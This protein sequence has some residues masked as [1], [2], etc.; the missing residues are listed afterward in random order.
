MSLIDR[1][2]K[3]VSNTLHQVAKDPLGAGKKAGEQLK[4]G[5]DTYKK[6]ST[7]T[8]DVFE[9]VRGLRAD[10]FRTTLRNNIDKVVSKATDPKTKLD[11]KG[12]L[13]IAGGVFG[14]ITSA[15]KLPKQIG[16]A[17]SD[18]RNAVRSGSRQDWDKAVGSV[19]AAGKGVV[20]TVKGGL[21][22]ARDAHKFGSAYKAASGAFKAAVPGAGPKLARAAA[23]AA[24]KGA[25]EGAGRTAMRAGVRAAVDGA[26]RAGGTA[27][28]TAAGTATR[29]A[30][31]A[32]LNE[33][34]KAAARAA[35]TAAAR[36]AAGP[37]AKAAGRF[38]P[39]ANVAIAAFDV[40][41]AYSTVRDPKASTTKKVT[42]VITAVG[43]V[44]AATNIPVV[45]Q[46]GA[47]VS[48]VSSFVGGLFG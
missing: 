3:T 19:A 14:T 39:G 42:S 18:I 46:V 20:S 30:A 15:A 32:A 27:V 25:F 26:V 9:N 8:K 48:A 1:A 13:G 47:A 45:S 16:T 36:A 21:D 4:K 41:S 17:A 6:V 43:S 28:R 40:A 11:L 44:A 22:I 10:G 35:T 24:A 33:G 37:L 38:A 5:Y 31:R 12:K 34:G 23:R 29:A 2:R 7:A